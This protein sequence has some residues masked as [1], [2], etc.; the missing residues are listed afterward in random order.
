MCRPY[1]PVWKE[2]SVHATCAVHRVPGFYCFLLFPIVS[3]CTSAVHRNL[4]FHAGIWVGFW[5]E[6]PLNK[7]PFFG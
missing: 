7:G 1:G 4:T 3:R 2:T 6:K 5:V